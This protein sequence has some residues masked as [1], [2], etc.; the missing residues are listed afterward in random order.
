M[1]L[2]DILLPYQTKFVDAKV[3]RKI[4]ISA[5]Q[6][7]KSF[8]SAYLLV[9]KALQKRNGVS[10]CISTGSRAAGEI[11]RKCGQWAEAVKVL[12]NGKI[13]YTAHF[14]NISFSNGSRVIS[15]PSS[16]DGANLR[17]FTAQM[18][19][20]D[21]AAFIRNLDDIVQ[22]IGP[23]LTRD[24]NAD[25]VLATTPAGKN[26]PFYELYQLALD[27]P[28][29]YVQETNIYQAKAQGLVVDI[30]SLKS[31]CPD[32]DR[33][34][35]EY[36]CK[37]LSEYGSMIDT[38]LLDQYDE[39][40]EGQ[41]KAFLGMDIGSKHDRSAIVI[42]KLIKDIAYV[43]DIVVLSKMKYEDQLEILRQT[44][45]KHNVA[46]G[47]IDETGIGSAVAEFA[48]SKVSRLIKGLTFTG[49]NKTPM[50]EAIRDAVF[51]H[52]IKFNSKFI[53]IVTRDIQNVERIV[54]E[55]G[56]VKYQAS[57]D[58]NGHS[59]I[60]SGLVLAYK[61][62]KDGSYASPEVKTWSMPSVFRTHK[63]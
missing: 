6:L 16:T 17:G 54:T 53:D 37:F 27:D 35:Q 44:N 41:S 32:S 10:L 34:A 33:F 42:V 30:D 3:H 60:T 46:S 52:K 5:R 13:D 20:C 21:E 12:S 29:W 43:D 28:Q 11:I 62:L 51:Q 8:T 39:L 49:A 22:A 50:H 1:T 59:D 61:A 23:T 2:R 58:E 57:R 36:E 56:Q 25:L 15:L 48:N 9:Q 45:I 18:V 38:S 4:W 14:D 55:S 7:G 19:L 26:G 63:F 24:P 40:P 31:L 47:Y